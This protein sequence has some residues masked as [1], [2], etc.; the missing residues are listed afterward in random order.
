MISF[1]DISQSFERG[2]VEVAAKTGIH[3][4][5][6]QGKSQERSLRLYA[7]ETLLEL[8]ENFPVLLHIITKKF[9]PYH[10]MK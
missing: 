3:I 8:E 5:G 7:A 9:F 10:N 2:F 6:I 1:R 4:G